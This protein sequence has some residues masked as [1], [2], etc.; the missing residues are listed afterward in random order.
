MSLSLSKPQLKHKHKS[1]RNKINIDEEYSGLIIPSNPQNTSIT[2]SCSSKNSTQQTNKHKH[3]VETRN[4][5]TKWK[6]EICHYWEVNQFCK[7]GDKVNISYFTNIN[8]VCI[9]TW[10]RRYKKQKIK[11]ELQN[12]TM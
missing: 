2:T 3:S 7:F 6:T 11:F 5:R 4:F 12:K 10:K 8:I 1:K 9:C